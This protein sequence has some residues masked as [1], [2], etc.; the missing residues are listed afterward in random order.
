MR[1]RPDILAPM[2]DETLS[3]RPAQPKPDE[4]FAFAGYLDID[5]DGIFRFMLGGASERV[6]SSAFITIGHDLS[7]EHVTFVELD[8]I[9]VG[10]TSDYSASQHRDSSDGPLVSAAGWRV[11]RMAAVSAVAPRPF[12]FID[13]VP[14]GDHYLQAIAVD[15]DTR[16]KGIGTVLFD[17]VENRARAAGCERLALDVAV[18]NEDA[19][20]LYER[21]GLSIDATSPRSFLGPGSRVYQMAKPL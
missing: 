10:M 2:S 21:L 8:G 13:T 14:D 17:R 19:R 6:L 3:L 11:V 12:R 18:E 7:Y 15:A 16:G 9:V 5:A 4:G 20:R 1:E